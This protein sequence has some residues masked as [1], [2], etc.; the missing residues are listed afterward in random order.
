MKIAVTGAFGYSG[1]YIARRLLDQG[2]EVITLTNSLHRPNPF[3][4]KI[5]AFPFHFDRP[6]RLQAQLEGVE[7][8]I[9]TYWVRFDY[10][11]F[12]HGAAVENSLKLFAAARAAGVRRI[13]H[14]S[15]TNPS[16][17]SPLPYFSGK[18]QLE[19]A[20]Q[21]SGLS[22]AILRPTVLFGKEDILINNIAWALRHLPVFGVF[23]DGRYRLQPIYVDDLARLAVAQ[24]ARED[25][26][27]I[28]AIGPETYTYRDLVAEIAAAIGVRRPVISVPPWFGY[29]VGRVIGL[30]VGDVFITREEIEGLMADLLYV[31]APPAGEVRL[32][33]WAR[34]HA[35]ELGRH[36]ASE[37][38][39]RK[40]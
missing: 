17:D 16:L 38:A 11:T 20:L 19:L 18:A 8:L 33:R 25:D 21:E 26:V 30:L 39:R 32:S 27:I 10:K 12:S 40:R 28:N 24:A 37:L 2:H 9:N 35:Q 15:I 34:E 1:R 3:G 4:E 23:G 14:V 31:D 29:Q 22:Y 7:V 36:Y 13:V 5:R 6:E